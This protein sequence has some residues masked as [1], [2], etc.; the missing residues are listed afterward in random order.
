MLNQTHSPPA[1]DSAVGIAV[2]VLA[3]LLLVWA[4]SKEKP[5][6]G[7][8][9]HRLLGPNGVAWAIPI[10]AIL[11]ILVEQRVGMF[12]APPSA[13]NVFPLVRPTEEEAVLQ[14]APEE[15]EV[16]VETAGRETRES[17]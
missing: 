4:A 5:L 15:E 14:M 1:A 12:V 10:A 17:G 2:V 6:S 3:I 13:V 11:V 8:T 16:T 9:L 7:S